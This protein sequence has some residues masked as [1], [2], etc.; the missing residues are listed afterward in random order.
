MPSKLASLPA[1]LLGAILS[2]GVSEGTFNLWLT[3]DY[4]IQRQITLGVTSIHLRNTQTFSL[5][6][7]PQFIL[8][9]RKL[10]RFI[11]DRASNMLYQSNCATLLI[12]KLPPT[13][14]ELR[15]RYANSAAAL[16]EDEDENLSH[17]FQ[18]EE[19]ITTDAFA[20]DLDDKTPKEVENSRWK[21]AEAFPHLSVLEISELSDFN[22]ATLPS[23]LTDLTTTLPPPRSDL[24]HFFQSL[25]RQLLRLE[26]TKSRREVEHCLWQYLPPGL[27][28]YV[29]DLREDDKNPPPFG[30]LRLPAS[31]TDLRTAYFI[32]NGASLSC[33]PPS[34]TSIS[35]VFHDEFDAY[36]KLASLLPNL[37]A[38]DL[39]YLPSHHANASFLRNLPSTLTSMAIGIDLAQISADDWPSSLVE[40][41]L[42]PNSSFRIEAIP[43]KLTVLEAGK[44]HI[45]TPS[46][47]ALLPQSLT[48]L[49]CFVLKIVDDWTSFPP[50][51]KALKL[52]ATK[53][54]IILERKMIEFEYPEDHQIEFTV[55]R[56]FIG[57]DGKTVCMPF[58]LSQSYLHRFLS[59]ERVSKCFPFGLLPRTITA[60]RTSAILPF[61]KLHELPPRL[62]NLSLKSVFK[63]A[64][65]DPDDVAA[66]RQIMQIGQEE[67]VVEKFDSSQLHHVTLSS[68]LPRSLTD[69]TFSLAGP[70]VGEWMHLP[71]N[72]TVLH[73]LSLDDN[74]RTDSTSLFEILKLNLVDICM[75]VQSLTDE[76]CKAMPRCLVDAHFYSSDF[77]QLTSRGAFYSPPSTDFFVSMAQAPKFRT[78]QLKRR[79]CLNSL[80]SQAD[81]N[82]TFQ[83]IFN[84]HENIEFCHRYFKVDSIKD[85]ILIEIEST[86]D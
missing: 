6:K 70:G 51:L 68:M 35:D 24:K 57:A 84:A 40:L 3:G 58:D 10:R 36:D 48:D 74:Q 39:F 7:L 16:A 73:C 9:L 67:G 45:I 77:S 44:P 64:D 26:L 60:L 76:H 2:F 69:I 18:S 59:G 82:P 27:Q 31:L 81:H 33:L 34:I 62:T 8:K 41:V 28:T 38:V 49:S 83:K 43:P 32:P 78:V 12:R 4:A 25:P 5:T 80:S 79:R 1:E 21:L 71:P 66:M 63:D 37:R 22:L 20:C 56:K 42:A 23:S 61:S 13:L 17:W 14:T 53:D 19:D 86:V 55:L 52:L 65:F 15:L 47:M 11:V 72:L 50:R 85:R 29:S 75:A 30:D 46:D 54:P